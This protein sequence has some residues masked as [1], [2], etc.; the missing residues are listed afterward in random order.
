[1]EEGKVEA[2]LRLCRRHRPITEA[3]NPRRV[4][5]QPAMGLERERLG[6]ADGDFGRAVL[7]RHIDGPGSIFIVQPRVGADELAALFALVP[8]VLPP[9]APAL[10]AEDDGRR[11]GERRENASGPRC[12]TQF[13]P[14]GSDPFL[15]KSRERVLGGR[16]SQ[17]GL[18]GHGDCDGGASPPWVDSRSLKSGHG[19]CSRIVESSISLSGFR[20]VCSTSLCGLS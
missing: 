19:P 4:E 18:A 11:E 3:R 2:R 1:M 16:L 20:D 5:E 9:A 7:E 12:S 6:C 13:R 15:R 17:R 8:A 10:G 14:D